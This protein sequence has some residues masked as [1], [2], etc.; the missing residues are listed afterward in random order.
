MKPDQA[1][2]A[3]KDITLRQLQSFGETA[4]LGSLTAAA[5][6]LGLAHP[7]VWKQVH[8]LEEHFGVR[9]VVPHGRG[10]ALTDEGK[11]LAALSGPL[12]RD[13][14]RIREQFG[15]ERTRL[16]NKL[17]VAASARILIE[18]VPDPLDEFT[19][20]RPD[21]RVSLRQM[22]D[23]RVF[24]AVESGEADVGLTA[25]VIPPETRPL[26][27]CTVACRLHVAVIAPRG[28]PIT[29]LRKLHPSD[30][31]RWPLVNSRDTFRNPAINLQLERYDAFRGQPRRVEAFSGD[32]VREYVR[33][34]YGLGVIAIWE[35]YS[36]DSDLWRRPMNRWFDSVTVY[37]VTRNSPKR[38][39]LVQ[40]FLDLFRRAHDPGPVR[41]KGARSRRSVGDRH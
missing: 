35:T 29:R 24:D 8:A 13:I 2:P 38:Q 21:V 41:R 14:D 4:R 10:C 19:R 40:G 5:R 22:E 33:R 34:G 32:S 30:L 7:T 18:A 27:A 20:R 26:L 11:V 23:A 9:L 25:S 31:G 39:E 3:Y 1:G 6:Q 36:G 28:H 17:C 15:T 12:V 37:A 16:A